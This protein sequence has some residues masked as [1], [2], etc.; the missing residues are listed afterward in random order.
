MS[1][2]QYCSSV[3]SALWAKDVEANILYSMFE[4]TPNFEL[5]LLCQRIPYITAS[6]YLPATIY[7]KALRDPKSV[8]TRPSSPTSTQRFVLVRTDPSAVTQHLLRRKEKRNR[9]KPMKRVH[10]S[11]NSYTIP[12]LPS[13]LHFIHLSMSDVYFLSTGMK[14]Y[15]H[16]HSFIVNIT[17]A[18]CDTIHNQSCKIFQPCS[19]CK[20][21]FSKTIACEGHRGRGRGQAERI[22]RKGNATKE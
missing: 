8:N 6:P 11:V 14:A 19:E 15:F 9:K 3:T 1:V 13:I 18:F 21:N 17:N 2:W 10:R 16:L 7:Q 22:I 12:F 4:K 5:I 20:I